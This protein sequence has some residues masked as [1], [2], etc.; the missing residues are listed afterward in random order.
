MGRVRW[1]PPRSRF[2][3]GSTRY[4]QRRTRSSGA[5]PRRRVQGPP[6]LEDP[7]QLAKGGGDVGDGAQRQGGQGGVVAVVREGQRLPVEAGPLDRDAGC[8]D[9]LVGQFPGQVSGLDRVHP[10]DRRR[11]EREVETRAEADLDHDPGQTFADPAAYRF[12]GLHAASDV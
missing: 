7:A 9:A 12:D 5:R 2:C 11:V 6:G 10:G 1:H 3:I 4:C 8:R